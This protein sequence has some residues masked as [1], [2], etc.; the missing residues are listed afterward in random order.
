MR[1]QVMQMLAQVLANN[2]GNKLTLE[3]ANGIATTFN[4]AWTQLEEEAAKKDSKTVDDVL[5]S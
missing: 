4:Q 1:E 5:T 2:I 3:M